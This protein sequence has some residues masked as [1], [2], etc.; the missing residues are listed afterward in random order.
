MD[1]SSLIKQDLTNEQ[2]IDKSNMFSNTSFKINQENI[3]NYMVSSKNPEK[4]PVFSP[5]NSDISIKNIQQDLKN[6]NSNNLFP[7]I[8]DSSL[9]SIEPINLAIK[10]IDLNANY[11]NA[12]K[13][14]VNNPL[15]RISIINLNRFLHFNNR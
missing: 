6:L 1:V 15:Q 3:N 2:D 12:Y 10:S 8:V 7:I 11:I 13:I 5:T 14:N 9:N 4:S